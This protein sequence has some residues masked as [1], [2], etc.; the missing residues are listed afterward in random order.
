M[1][2]R[3]TKELPEHLQVP[4]TAFEA[5]IVYILPW[6]VLPIIVIL[7]AAAIAPYSHDVRLFV[8]GIQNN[9]I[10]ANFEL[11]LIDAVGELG[12]VYLYLKKYKVGW[13]EAG[14]RKFS[15]LGALALLGL[16][17]IVFSIGVYALTI[18]VSLLIP[19]FNANQAQTNDFTTQTITHPSLTL[20][21]LVI[22]PPIIEETVFRG[23]IF[24]AMSKRFGLIFGAITTSILFG[25]AHL[26]ANVSIYTFVL[27]LVLCFMY[28]RLKSIIPGIGLHMLNNYLAYVA[29]G[30]K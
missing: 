12:I 25:L 9:D 21:A 24:P 20:L 16:M 23:F 8:D 30:M 28:V 3:L 2:K 18:A 10:V 5:I 26:Q 22:I 13:R 14:W 15:F 19:A 29:I 11:V 1:H 6:I 27:S 4:W 7:V 17:F